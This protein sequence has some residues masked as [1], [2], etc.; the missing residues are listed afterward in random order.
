MREAGELMRGLP[1]SPESNGNELKVV[2]GREE[3]TGGRNT[4]EV[5]LA[6]SNGV[7]CREGKKEGSRL[8]PRFLA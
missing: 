4:Q 8:A 7:G 5:K 2:T 1:Q 3:K 6:R